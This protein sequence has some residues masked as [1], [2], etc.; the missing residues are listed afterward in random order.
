MK[1]N[2]LNGL[3]VYTATGS[4]TYPDLDKGKDF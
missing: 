3:K 1:Q 4:L 2:T